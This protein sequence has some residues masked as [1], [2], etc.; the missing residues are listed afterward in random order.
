MLINEVLFK[1]TE[2]K[3]LAPEESALISQTI[4]TVQSVPDS[5]EM[6]NQFQA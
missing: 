4:R 1:N 2:N 3:V 6:T 5:E